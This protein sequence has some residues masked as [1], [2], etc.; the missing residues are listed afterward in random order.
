MAGS[1]C[2]TYRR[3]AG[4]LGPCVRASQG[5]DVLTLFSWSA[6]LRFSSRSSPPLLV[7]A[8]FLQERE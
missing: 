6:G 2:L 3:L 7:G 1:L 5:G 8:P 4:C